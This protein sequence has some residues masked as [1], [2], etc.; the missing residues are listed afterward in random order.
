MA[1]SPRTPLICFFLA[2]ST[3]TLVGCGDTHVQHPRLLDATHA[4][5]G[6]IDGLEPAQWIIEGEGSMTTVRT[7]SCVSIRTRSETPRLVI[8][9]PVCIVEEESS[10]RI[11]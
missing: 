2:A 6:K 8:G 1:A 10:E 4:R 11:D 5:I 9:E 7:I 3:A